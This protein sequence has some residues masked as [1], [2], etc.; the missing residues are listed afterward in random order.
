MAMSAL[1]QIAAV[2]TSAAL[3]TPLSAETI[4][5]TDDLILHVKNAAGSSMTVTFN[6]YG[7]TPAG[8]TVTTT[9]AVTIPA[10]TGDKYIFVQSTLANPATGIITANFSSTTSV[11]AEWLRM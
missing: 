5:A 1:N 2:G 10:T 11:T 3:A 9:A 6:D 8:T 4:L 7:L